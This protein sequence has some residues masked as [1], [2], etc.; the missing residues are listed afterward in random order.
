V[1]T[2][3]GK[4]IRIDSPEKILLETDG[5]SL[6]HTPLEF[7]IIPKSIRIITGVEEN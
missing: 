3:T 2:Y 6:G 7:N 5:E 1:T 4:E